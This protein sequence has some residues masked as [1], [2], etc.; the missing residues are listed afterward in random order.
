MTE[1]PHHE[2]LRELIDRGL[3]T[4]Q[5]EP[6]LLPRGNVDRRPDGARTAWHALRPDGT[7]VKL[8]LGADLADLA[9]RQA[10]LADACP[11]LVP[12]VLLSEKLSSGSVLAE[13]FFEG[14]ALEAV[15]AAQSLPLGTILAAL[16]RVEAALAATLQPSDE[17]ARLAEWNLWSASLLALPQ[18]IDAERGILRETILPRLYPL[19][20]TEPPVTRWSNGDFTPA[21]LLVN[22]KGDIRLIDFEFATRTHFFPEDAVRFYELSPACRRAEA[23]LSAAV[24]PP[25]PG[26]HLFFWLRQLRLEAENNTAEYVNRVQ[27]ARRAMIR[28]LAEQVLGGFLDGWPVAATEVQ[29]HLEE[30]HW[31]QTAQQDLVLT[32]WCHAPGSPAL[33]SIVATADG[34]RLAAARLTG[35]PDVQQHFAG[36]PRAL[37]SGFIL[38]VPLQGKD[39]TLLLSAATA[40]GTLRPFHTIRS[41]DMP[42]RG[43]AWGDYASWAERCDPDPPPPA[44]IPAGGPLFS[45][46][47]PVF[48]TPPPFL[49]ACLDSVR[50]QHYPH[51][52]LCIVDDGSR[53][54]DVPGILL[55]AARDKR[56]RVQTS[57]AN[58]GIARATNLALAMATGEFVVLLDH[59][60]LLRPH[61]LRELA[62]RLAGEP[63]L[64]ALYSD[65]DA[66]TAD[67]QRVHPFLKP[68]FSPE[69]LLGVMYAGHVLCVRAAVARAA[70]GFDPAFDGVQDY[71]FLLRVTEHTSRIGHLPRMLYPWRQSPA[72]SARQG[73]IKGDMDERQA[74]AVRAHLQRRGRTDRAVALGGHRVRLLAGGA[75]PSTEIFI[76]PGLNPPA[77]FQARPLTAGRNALDGLRQ[78]AAA[79]RAEIVAILT[80]PPLDC[81]EN[82]LRELAAVAARPDSALVAPV[83][84]A[85]EGRLLESGWTLGPAGAAPLMRG[86]DPAGDGYH[87]S[88]RCNRE[89]AAV[90]STCIAIRRALLRDVLTEIS[91][92][93]GW[94]EFC[95]ALA[96]RG[97]F[98]RV[99][100]AAQI[101]V[102]RSWRD[103]R[104]VE[105]APPGGTADRF[106]NRHFDPGSA[107]YSLRPDLISP[108]PRWH[109][110]TPPPAPADNGCG[111]WRGWCY[112]P[113]ETIDVVRV[114][115]ASGLTW[116]ARYGLSR[117]DVP[118]KFTHRIPTDCGFELR[119]R[120]PAGR[121][122]LNFEA[123]TTSGV[124]YPL[125]CQ[126]VDVTFW[127]RARYSLWG[128]AVKLGHY[129][130]MT[131]PSTIPRTVPAPRFP[132]PRTA[133][134]D[135]PRIAI[136]TPAFQHAAYLEQCL[137]SV[138]EQTRAAVQYVVQDGGSTDGSAELIKNHAARLFAWESAPDAGQADAIVKGFAKTSGGP[139]DL[140]A[141]R[142]PS[143][144]HPP[145]RGRVHWSTP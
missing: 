139:D 1:P 50:S 5:P 47:L 105:K 8:T 81:P 2:I 142:N 143:R 132:P 95:R 69:F 4:G 121:H 46:L 73:N 78:A 55:A 25:A 111:H 129:Q 90:S 20:A 31:A 82:W 118:A 86:F 60:D 49:R 74:A 88:L 59:D 48:N 57:P 13:P 36:D 120:L 42:G 28:R 84:L 43:P 92:D 7:A 53:P 14:P 11:E 130:L 34:R 117:P 123:I 89:V 76:A 136:I 32:G 65:E 3:I 96:A 44:N 68:D 97:L 37:M 52:E 109:L 18:W 94:L 108:Q 23:V 38:S 80:V 29:F 114:R 12:P 112:L 40:D 103:P 77:W 16:A 15:L 75:L 135:R 67:G 71:E 54:P 79:S 26:W 85:R 51:W 45:I 6:R 128:A 122:E 61:A 137:R 138:L 106:F 134:K 41:G 93:S 124:V 33:D 9:R 10:A 30:A 27:P 99:C 119:L 39:A 87:G 141:W 22:A 17:A 63:E 83:L 35:R 62:Q 116:P 100:A 115:T 70:G 133:E 24:A 66:I 110:D 72:S 56:V 91:A 145:G 21:N 127:Q 104:P 107:D 98:H 113:G 126:T 101:T 102:D 64:D 125:F 144:W 140:M 58:G 19:L 131:A